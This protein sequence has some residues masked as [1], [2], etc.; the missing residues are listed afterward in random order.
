[1]SIELIKRANNIAESGPNV[2]FCIRNEKFRLDYFLNYYRKIGFTKFWAVDNLST[3]ET[4]QFLA[5]QSDVTLFSTSASYKGS[6]AGRDWTS[7]VADQYCEDE[8]CL[9]V[10]VDEYFVFPFVEAVGGISD[11]IEY[12]DQNKYQGVF[13]LFLDYYSQ[14]PLSEVEYQ[15]GE[16]PFDVCSFVDRASSYMTHYSPR[17]PYFEVKGGPRR[18]HFWSREGVIAGPSM[19]KVPLVRWERGFEYT[20]ATHS[21]S[22][23]RL[24]DITS[25]IAH[26]KLL[27]H[28]PKFAVEEVQR[29][30]RVSNSVDWRRYAKAMDEEDQCFFNIDV[31]L[32][33]SSSLDLLKYEHIA[34]SPQFNHFVLECL[35]QKRN[36]VVSDFATKALKFIGHGVKLDE[37]SKVLDYSGISRSW[38]TLS[39]HCSFVTEPNIDSENLRRIELSIDAAKDS[40]LWRASYHFR[41]LASRFGLTDQRSITEEVYSNQSL[42]SKFTFIYDSIWWDLLGPFRVVEKILIRL[43]FIKSRRQ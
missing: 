31:S 34:S 7:Y 16:N 3:D 33:V 28:F 18:R 27:G 30:E 21:C 12:L 9:T 41:K 19:R 2:I 36:K 26:F 10:D 5:L 15:E 13:A 11:L 14:K 35:N 20:V 43:G 22:P 1:V 17:F 38:L 25:A 24:A 4:A 23:I 42:H 40:R 8:W 37:R 32:E 39:Q 29:N 6:N